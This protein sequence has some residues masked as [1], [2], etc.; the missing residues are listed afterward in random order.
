EVV[1]GSYLLRASLGTES[2]AEMPVTVSRGDVT[3]PDL[4]LAPAVD[5]PYNVRVTGAPDGVEV[6]CLVSAW[7]AGHPLVNARVMLNRAQNRVSDLLP[8]S[9]RLV[10]SCGNG[11]ITSALWG[12]QDL[13]ANPEIVIQPGATPQPIEI[14]AH[15]G[16]G[17][18]E[19]K[20]TGVKQSSDALAILLVP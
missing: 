17:S 9:H 4:A 14:V 3:L 10:M 16:G 11:Y 2:A 7:T 20:L 19:G 13:L 5:V 1:P 18:I 12:S 6:S 8:G 15:A